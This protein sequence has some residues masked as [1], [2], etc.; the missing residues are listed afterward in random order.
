MTP[1][2]RS[3]HT[4][5]AVAVAALALAPSAL[6][7]PAPGGV[8]AAPGGASTATARTFSWS[9]VAPDA[10]G[11]AVAYE[12][13]VTT[14]GAPPGSPGALGTGT[15][16]S[17][18]VPEGQ[19]VT[20][21]VR[22]VETL[23]GVPI[24]YSGYAATA[25]F[26]SDRTAPAVTASQSPAA[27]PRAWTNA[28]TMVTFACADANPGPGAWCPAPVALGEGAG[29]VVTGSATDALGQTT[30]ISTTVNVDVTPPTGGAPA[31]PAPGA[32]VTTTR[33]EFTWAA[34]ADPLSGIQY[35]EVY[36]VGRGKVGS[37]TA[38]STRLVSFQTLPAGPLQWYVRTVD[39]A[40][41]AAVSSRSA[42]TIDPTATS[43]SPDPPATSGS[44]SGSSAPAGTPPSPVVRP[45]RGRPQARPVSY[46]ARALRPRAGVKL[47]YLRPVLRWTRGPRSTRLYNV[48]IFEIR[49]RKVRK[50]LTAFPRTTRYRVP[51]GK[52]RRDRRYVWRVWPYAAG[53]YTARPKGVSYFDIRPAPR[54]AAR[55]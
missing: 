35:Y 47:T 11:D 10:G 2:P 12:G 4:R 36:V 9:P 19:Q 43:Q 42:L 55:S 34:A 48:Q 41:N 39:N 22:S 44:T 31:T 23:A 21:W 45:S 17:L 5:V 54:R 40:N 14:D 8:T 15:S 6:A 52:L 1:L 29:Q 27:N 32:T 33:P 53:R 24:A 13:G 26:I 25:P 16:V 46:N 7:A 30:T 38:R 3:S 18:G 20:F 49:G 37:T 50:V 51:S 28:P